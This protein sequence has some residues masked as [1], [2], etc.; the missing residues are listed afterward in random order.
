MTINLEN[1]KEID[2]DLIKM[3]TKKGP[4]TFTELLHITKL[5]RKT[6]SLRLRTL[7]E[8]GAIVKKEGLYKLNGGA[9]FNGHNG[10]FARDFSRILHDRRIRTGLMLITF[11]LFSSAS[12][13]VLGAFL[14]PEATHR[15]PVLLGNFKMTLDINSDVKDLYAWQTIIAFDPSE[16]RVLNIAS[17]GFLGEDFPFFFN[18]TNTNEGS[19]LVGGTLVGDVTGRN[20]PGEL[21]T[22]TFGYFVNQ[23]KTPEI[24]SDD[25]RFNT[26]LLNSEGLN[27]FVENS[28]TLTL[29]A[30]QNP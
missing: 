8:E 30:I 25:G 14:I 29:N 28:N 17:S 19:I 22:I 5:S 13:Y 10:G 18:G 1:R 4:R 27:I 23:Y 3:A 16:V 24:V 6:L 20:G 26:F 12:G 21:A 2:T 7:C 9:D 15:D 11:L